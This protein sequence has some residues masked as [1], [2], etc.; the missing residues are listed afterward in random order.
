MITK[1]KI[2]RVG[3]YL[4]GKNSAISENEANDVLKYFR[5]THQHPMTLFRHTIDRKL[6]KHDITALVSQRLKRIPS[7]VKKLKIQKNMSLSRMQDIGGLRIVVNTI[8]EVDLIRA[9]L[10][11]TENHSNFKFTFVNEEDYIKTPPDSGYRSIHMIY[12]YDKGIDLNKQCRVE[13]QI[14]TKLQ[15]SWAT[16]VEV[17]GTYLNQPLKQGF[18]EDKYLSIFKKISKLFISLETKKIDYEFIQEVE[19]D[20]K[21][22]ELLQKLQSFNIVSKHL[23]SNAK[24][25]YVL[26]KMSFKKGDIEISQYSDAKFEQ[27]NKDYLDMELENRDNK[28][29]EIVLISIQDIKK[30]QQ[31]YPNY[32]MDTT[33]FIKNMKKLFKLV[34][35]NEKIQK[36][37]NSAKNKKL[38]EIMSKKITEKMFELF[39]GGKNNANK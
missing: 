27:A 12:K 14:R 4:I 2:N 38:A 28:T 9:E 26:L 6:K 16:A 22:I 8:D 21:K 32:F 24:G 36:M 37:I 5:L 35:E 13:I 1:G 17:T 11:K 19:Q 29:V 39:N 18:G 3:E 10:K 15:H 25:K 23:E 31:S 7:I 20:I 34:V 30:L 33:D